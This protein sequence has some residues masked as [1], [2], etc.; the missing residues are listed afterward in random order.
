LVVARCDLDQSRI[1]KETSFNFAAHRR[2]EHYGLI[3][4]RAGSVPPD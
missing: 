4:E 2:I 1:Y 3:T